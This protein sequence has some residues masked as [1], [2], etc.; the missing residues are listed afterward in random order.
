MRWLGES[1]EGLQRMPASVVEVV[2]EMY[3]DEQEQIARMNQG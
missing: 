3:N 1:W 2:I